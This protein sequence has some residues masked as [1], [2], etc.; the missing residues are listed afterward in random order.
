MRS[1]RAEE[2]PLQLLKCRARL[3]GNYLQQNAKSTKASNAAGGGWPLATAVL[4][5]EQ[6]Q[7]TLE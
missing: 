5:T 6:N 2:A 7:G 4:C 3:R 1:F